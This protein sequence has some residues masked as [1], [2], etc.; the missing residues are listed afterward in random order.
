MSVSSGSKL[1]NLGIGHFTP[2]FLTKPQCLI[3]NHDEDNFLSIL[4]LIFTINIIW[5]MREMSKVC[6]PSCQVVE[7]QNKDAHASAEGTTMGEVA[8]SK[9]DASLL[10]VDI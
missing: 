8:A 4:S 10:S 6:H 3:I 2:P 5:L 9:T 1:A 7:S